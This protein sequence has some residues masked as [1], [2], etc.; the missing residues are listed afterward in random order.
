MD[1]VL[2]AIDGPDE[3]DLANPSADPFAPTDGGGALGAVV[4]AISEEDVDVDAAVGEEA[5]RL[6]GQ[7]AEVEVR[8]LGAGEV[9]IVLHIGI[10]VANTTDTAGR[11]EMTW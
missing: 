11:A 2:D 3:S 7:T 9:R 6:V 10:R 5:E 8:A 4:Q 1:L